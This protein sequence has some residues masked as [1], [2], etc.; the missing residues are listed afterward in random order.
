[1]TLTGKE[2][3]T[4]IITFGIVIMFLIRNFANLGEIINS[5]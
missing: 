3:Q 2:I 5:G 1:M 4:V